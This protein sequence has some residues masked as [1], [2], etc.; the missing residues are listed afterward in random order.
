MRASR[1]QF[2]AE[3]ILFVGDHDAGLTW[4]ERAV[5]AGLQDF[6][7]LERCPLLG[8]LRDR[9]R[10]QELVDQLRERATA[11]LASVRS[12]HP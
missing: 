1:L 7:W 2:L 11:V 8:P 5:E 4:V 9:P 3:F 12:A 6:I 10:F